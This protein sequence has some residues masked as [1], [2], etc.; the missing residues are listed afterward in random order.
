MITAVSM[1]PPPIPVDLAWNA[2]AECPSPAPDDSLVTTPAQPGSPAPTE[3]SSAMP[4]PLARLA[5]TTLEAETRLV[6]AGVAALHAGDN[7]RALALFDEHA[8]MFP[9]G[10][11]AEERAAER[12]IVLGELRRCDEAR[13]A[14]ASFL[15]DHSS[16]PLAARVGAVCKAAPNP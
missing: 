8:R 11:L 3:P 13:S 2:P 4:S 7:T 14:A 5:P 15:R 12:V 9:R 1:V 16:S 10:A 6:R